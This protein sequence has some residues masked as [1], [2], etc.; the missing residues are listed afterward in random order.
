MAVSGAYR[1]DDDEIS[2]RLFAIDAKNIGHS[3]YVLECAVLL[4]PREEVVGGV[5]AAGVVA[6]ED[7]EDLADDVVL[8]VVGTIGCGVAVGGVATVEDGPLVGANV[9]APDNGTNDVDGRPERHKL[10]DKHLVEDS[11]PAVATSEDC[12]GLWVA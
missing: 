2:V 7:R 8:L 4:L 1:N 12:G 9:P 6:S 3:V 10:V 5:G 11:F